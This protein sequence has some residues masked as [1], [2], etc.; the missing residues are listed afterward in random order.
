MSEAER[1]RIADIAE[2]SFVTGIDDE[3]PIWHDVLVRLAQA[4]HASLSRRLDVVGETPRPA[5]AK[6]AGVSVAPHEVLSALRDSEGEPMGATEIAA[7][8]SDERNQPVDTASVSRA[9]K[10]LLRAKSIEQHGSKRGAKYTAVPVQMVMT[11][12]GVPRDGEAA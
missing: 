2:G 12:D 3:D 4:A 8:I 6:P 7:A 9:L 5:T 11:G 10:T 1:T